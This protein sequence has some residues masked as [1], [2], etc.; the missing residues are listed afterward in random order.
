MEGVKGYLRIPSS[1]IDSAIS[2]SPN[3][4]TVFSP[5]LDHSDP[6]AF[7]IPFSPQ[8]HPHPPAL[9]HSSNPTEEPV[10]PKFRS[11][12]TFILRQLPT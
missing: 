3:P 2:S 10:H 5:S 6:Y 1:T 12:P 11:L 4:N 9:S 8:Q 7:D